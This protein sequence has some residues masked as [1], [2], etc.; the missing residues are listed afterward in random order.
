MNVSTEDI[1]GI[2]AGTVKPFVCENALAMD[3]GCSLV[4]RLKRIGNESADKGFPEGVVN[5]E[6]KKFFA[7]DNDGINI[8]L[9]HAMREGDPSVF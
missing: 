7:K 5:Y 8:L 2:K 1:R 9:I 6:T 3:S 4:T